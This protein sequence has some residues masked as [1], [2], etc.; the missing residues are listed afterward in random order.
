MLR[1]Y[2][3]NLPDTTL[4]KLV[5]AFGSLRK[6]SDQGLI[7][8]PYS[9]REIVNIVKHLEKFPSDSL[10]NVLSNVYDFDHFADQSDLKNTFKEV[11][12][13]H[14]IAIE[15][16]SFQINLAKGIDM[17]SILPM[18]KLNFKLLVM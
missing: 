18:Q 16:S 4:S 10:S 13:K 1:I 5:S 14:G 2:A 9:T 6:L 3:P 12:K 17:P 8:Y 11:M 15:A 7:S